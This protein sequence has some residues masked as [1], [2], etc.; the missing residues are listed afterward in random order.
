MSQQQGLTVSEASYVLGRSPGIL[1]KAVDNGIIQARTRKV[2][3]IVHRLLGAAELRFLRLADELDK[4]L[5]PAGQRRLYGALRK[6][7]NDAH[8]LQLGKLE[9]DLAQIDT[10]LRSRMA[11]LEAVRG[12]IESDGGNGEASV[13]GTTI[14]AHL[15][16]AL[17]RENGIAGVLIDIPSLTK[18]QVEAAVEYAKAYPKRGRPYPAKSLK[19]TLAAMADA[20]AFDDLEDS[21]PTEPRAIP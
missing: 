6:L 7:P 12:R 17:A 1:N 9:L 18:D 3:K 13:R 4:D 10:D 2:G 11:K 5:T 19:S 20:G 15:V 16:A 21:V 14:S 8:R